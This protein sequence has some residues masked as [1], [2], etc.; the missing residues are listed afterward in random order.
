ML[1]TKGILTYSRY[2]SL[3][4]V[5]VAGLFACAGIICA[6]D[7]PVLG[8]P[9]NMGKTKTYV[10]QSKHIPN[11]K[12]L[13][14]IT[15]RSAIIIDSKSGEVL[16][17]KHPDLPRQPASTIKVLTGFLAINTL[18]P[19]KLIKVSRRAAKMPRSKLWLDSRKKYKAN[20][21]IHGVL[22]ASAND[23][24]VALAEHI[25]GSEKEF[26][27]LMTEQAKTWG[28][29]MTICRTASGL[30]AKGQQ[31]TARD[32][33]II[34]QHAMQDKEFAAKMGIN[35]IKTSFGSTL[36]TH[37]KALWQV[38][39]A[40][41]GKTGYT[42][43]A[44]QTYVGQFKSGDAEIIIALMGSETMW[45]DV[46]RL[47]D[48]GLTKRLATIDTPTKQTPVALLSKKQQPLKDNS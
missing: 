11:Y 31:S 46:K 43:K 47:A 21:L 48:H 15:A 26:A 14:Y 6:N 37:N 18:P 40:V 29:D 16:F 27:K 9:G 38:K 13:K 8:Q 32:L 33:A 20:D 30:T 34:F 42:N 41:G 17:E 3:L 5:S 2:L 4:F 25:A 23:A 36:Y 35:K 22:L 28:A 10:G 12:K 45:K 7:I 39:G 24:S 19:E 1:S 44:R